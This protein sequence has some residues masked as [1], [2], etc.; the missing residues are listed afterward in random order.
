MKNLFLLIFTILSISSVSLA[1]NNPV[2]AIK[3]LDNQ[4]VFVSLSNADQTN[5][6]TKVNYDSKNKNIEFSLKS[7]VS[8]V[9]IFNEEGVLEFQIMA[10]SK[11]IKLGE[12]LFEKGNYKLG[13][14]IKD[15]KSVQFTNL[16]IK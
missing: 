11:R 13:F 15:K 10:D 6:I 4:K 1:N 9:Q 12:S 14:I 16:T 8:H 2:E 3:L 5:N 7:D